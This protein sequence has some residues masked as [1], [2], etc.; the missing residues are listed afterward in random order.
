MVMVMAGGG[1]EWLLCID[2]FLESDDFTDP[3]VGGGMG[4]L[5]F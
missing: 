4:L 2:P 1:L 3:F 5:R